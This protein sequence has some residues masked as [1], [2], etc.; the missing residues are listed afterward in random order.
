MNRT[1]VV[2]YD[3]TAP[4]ERA[5]AE[6]TREAVT[7]G[8]AL[9]IVHAYQWPAAGQLSAQPE[10]SQEA[11]H[12]AAETLLEAA[13]DV[14]HAGHPEIVV[15]T[16]AVAGYAAAALVEACRDAELLVVGKRG[17]GGFDGLMVGSVSLR[18][19]AGVVCPVIVVRGD[20]RPACDRVLAAVDLAGP[21][22]RVFD[23]AFALASQRGAALTVVHVW[24]EPWFL[25]YNEGDSA[26]ENTAKVKDEWAIRLEAVVQPWRFK[27]SEVAVTELIGAGP[28]GA[29]LVEA[30]KGFD[31]LVVGAQRHG[32]NLHG[33][34]IGPVAHTALHHADCP[35]AVIPLD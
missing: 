2:G 31:L 34:R 29:E 9:R 20:E 35:V 27:Y 6:A 24:D 4:S 32:G 1:I 25:P 15:Q 21:C 17:A 11:C 26:F 10:M 8:G 23:F 14:V 19:L 12:E 5:L 33:M 22:D 30:S 3:H 13:A 28:A 7:R 16:R 18:A